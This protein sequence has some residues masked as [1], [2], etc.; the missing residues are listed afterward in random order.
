MFFPEK[1]QSAE[2]EH[3]PYLYVLPPIVMDWLGSLSHYHEP[4]YL[5]NWND[6]YPILI[7]WADPYPILMHC[8]SHTLS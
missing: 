1:F 7:H 5:I 3:T 8:R 2:N 6:F 4:N